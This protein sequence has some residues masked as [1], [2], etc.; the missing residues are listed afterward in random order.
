VEV[1][2]VDAQHF[3]GTFFVAAFT[4]GLAK[5]L[6]RGLERAQ[7]QP[8]FLLFPGGFG[9]G[10]GGAAGHGGTARRSFFAHGCCRHH[11]HIIV[12]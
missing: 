4:I 11:D 8:L 9:G 6:E 12:I 2:I 1:E 10:H 5:E 7:G 3:A